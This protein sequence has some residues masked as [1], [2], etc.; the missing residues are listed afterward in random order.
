VH[1]HRL[2]GRRGIAAGLRHPGEHD[3]QRRRQLRPTRDPG[4][5]AE[6][7]AEEEDAE[8]QEAVEEEAVQEELKGEEISE[9]SQGQAGP[10]QSKEG[11]QACA[12]S[13]E[14]EGR[15]MRIFG[16][17][18]TT[19]RTAA[20][21][22]LAIC[23][24]A[25]MTASAQASVTAAPGWEVESASYPSNLPPG[26][27]GTLVLAIYNV[28][29]ADSSG[30]V[31][32]TD[33][34][35][36]G[37]TATEAAYSGEPFVNSEF[38]GGLGGGEQWDCSVGSTVSCTND[39]AHLPS[40]RAGES[41]F[42]AIRVKVSGEASGQA[43]NEVTASGGGALGPAHVS[44]PVDFS[45]GTPMFGLQRLDAWFSNADGT[46]D[47]QAGSHPYSLTVTLAL[48]NTGFDPTGEARDITV[49]L[50]R[51]LIGNPTAVP[52]CTVAQLNTES[53]PMDT[54]VGV[55]RPTLGG[56]KSDLP[57][58]VVDSLPAFSF[59]VY[60]IVPPP[61]VPAQIGFSLLGL[62]TRINSQVR[63][64]SDYG[65]SEVVKNI[66]QS[67][68]TFNSITVW[69]VPADPSHDY[70]RLGP[71]NAGLGTGEEGI[72]YGGKSGI[73]PIPFL[74]LP[75]ACE[76]PQTFSTFTEPWAEGGIQGPPSEL[77]FVS[78]ENSGQAAGITGCDKL[79]FSPTI[80]VAPDT[81]DAET[82]AGLTVELK[83]PQEGLTAVEGLAASNIKDTTVTLP[84]GVDINP[85]QAHGLLTCSMAESA[86]GTEAESSCPNA[87]KV[88]TDEI[89]TPL[90]YHSLKGDVYVLDSNPPNLKLLVAASGEGVNLKLVG[91]VHLDEATGRLTT[92]FTETPELPFTTF[93]LSFSGGAQAALYT[94]SK[95]GS[96]Q[97][98]SDFTP[99][100]T[101]SVADA[102]PSS[103]FVVNAGPGGSACAGTLPF[104]PLLTAGSTTD[105]AGGFTDFSLLLSRADG[106]QRIEKLQFKAP[107]GLV[108]MLSKVPLCEEPQA[109]LGTCPAASQ[110][111]HTTVEA[112][113]GSAPL[114]VPEPGQAPAPIYLTGGYKGAPYGL[115]I[116]VPVIAGPFNLGTVVVRASIAVDP[117]TTQLTITTDPLPSIIDGVPT[118][119]RTINAVIDKP[120]FMINPTNCEAQSFS[121][122]AT[123]TEGATA[124]I[125]SPFGMGSCRS[126]EFKPKFTVSIPG[127]ASK[128]LGEG[129]TTTLSYPN[130][131]QGSD[132]NIA[133]VKVELPIQLPSQLKTLQ[134]ACIAATFEANPANCPEQSIVG[135]AKVTT[136]L[137]PV[138]LTGPAYFVS[139]AGEEFPSLTLV[140][141]GYGV[142]VDLVGTTFISKAGITSTTFKAAPDVPFN[143]FELTLPQGKY[144]AL[145]VNLPPNDNYNYCGQKLTMPTEL[146]AQNGAEINENTPISIEG[147]PTTLSISSHTV[148]K[149]TVTLSV[150]VPAAGKVKATGA[151]LTSSTKTSTGQET[152]T[153]TLTKTTR[154]KQTTRI[155][156]TYTP[157]KGHKQTKTLT[158][159]L[160]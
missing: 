64:G 91:D 107:K 13:H 99:W 57:L 16:A 103:E 147:C 83:T 54:Q 81:S 50:P 156:L 15:T 155:R 118:D 86:V 75:T 144:A 89:E 41:E 101:P 6:A 110:I 38:E 88:G 111:G 31:T 23:A 26:G 60:N 5:E 22:A 46:L 98:S 55:D 34:L 140:L 157:T 12:A 133:K 127:H 51:G 70:Q 40:I 9:A 3:V 61:G 102:F 72:Q 42:V 52:R 96:Y 93:R 152:I 138:P 11:R 97:T 65:I 77:S 154:H 49:N 78:H 135:H 142:T 85:G 28:G 73:N 8:L 115:S 29:K 113:P 21:A 130:V 151:G 62:G 24:V 80:S 19:H 58:T 67:Q 66:L 131:P 68:I 10:L 2:P 153:I 14:R 148:K 71:A 124:A 136:P 146:I 108:G 134:K 48:N 132:A 160:P 149:N 39:E 27:E 109:A 123:S 139:H 69:G 53:C 74:T 158:T 112:G 4:G 18:T 106:Q 35:P 87:S 59:P 17:L 137:L 117:H 32:V 44:I 121:G 45:A 114:V 82:P 30:Q 122:T 43:I 7:K 63:T 126:L 47:T 90:L 159:K 125:S 141:K 143:K 56:I 37:L 105:E 1:R 150:Y 116:V 84:E 25:G 20:I 104:A 119:L 79:S 92:T 95:C 100:S 145:G 128:A 129:L 36:A 120:E 33:T 94:P 76:G